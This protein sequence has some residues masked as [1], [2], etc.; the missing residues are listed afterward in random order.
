MID[1]VLYED[2]LAVSFCLFCDIS[3][4]YLLLLY[5]LGYVGW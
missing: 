4:F 5:R 1:F 3:H 2:P